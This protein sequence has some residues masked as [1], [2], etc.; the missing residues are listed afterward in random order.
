M[1]VIRGPMCRGTKGK[2]ESRSQEVS[3]AMV[4]IRGLMSRGTK[5]KSESRSQEVINRVKSKTLKG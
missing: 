5:G 3:Q 4:V 2:S 1:V